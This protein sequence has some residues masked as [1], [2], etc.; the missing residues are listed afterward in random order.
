MPTLTPPQ[1]EPYEFLTMPEM[2]AEGSVGE[3]PSHAT[4][5]RR[6]TRRRDR[7]LTPGNTAG[8]S[9][10]SKE[11][12]HNS[13]ILSRED[14]EGSSNAQPAKC[15]PNGGKCQHDEVTQVTA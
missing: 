14:G 5:A 10:P 2:V 4:T 1:T 12:P 6:K 15:H 7:C 9:R 13:V 11:P 8:L 3:R